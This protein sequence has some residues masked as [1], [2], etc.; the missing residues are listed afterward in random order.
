MDKLWTFG[1]S[2]TEGHGCKSIQAPYY[3]KKFKDY[4][5]INKKIWPELLSDSLKLEL[6]NLG[7]NG[8]SNEWIA[9][10]IIANIKNIST[11]DMVI[12]QTSTAGRYDFP[13]KKEKTLLG[14]SKNGENV[15]DF[16]IKT[17]DS[18][19]FFK[20]IF[21][22]NVIKEWDITLKDTL[23]YINA[24]QN[25]DDKELI[26]NDYKYNLIRGFFSEFISTEKYYE[27]GVW[28]IVQLS[29]VLSLMGIK[30][31]II[32]ETTWPEFL[33]KP[34]N[35][36]EMM[37]GGIQEYIY[38]HKKTIYHETMGKIDDYHPG[39]L[40]HIDISNYIVNFIQNEIK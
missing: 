40:G 2:F 37:S 18:P 17:N 26:L 20:T 4:I 14:S 5:D 13:F 23:R 10:T 32:N 29:N 27:R 38:K 22:T 35:L 16:I 31:Y 39:Y 3:Y 19:Y 36:I 7:K 6:V 34:D 24:Q 15:K 28:R 8:I 33:N 11:N 21:V 9:D 12:L 25:L 30:N 1:D